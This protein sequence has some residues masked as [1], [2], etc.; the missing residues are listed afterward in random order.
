MSSVIP[1]AIPMHFHLTNRTAQALV[2][3]IMREFDF[4]KKKCSRS[5]IFETT[6]LSERPRNTNEN[7]KPMKI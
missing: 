7:E 6:T 5:S 3:R 1:H 4:P 2:V